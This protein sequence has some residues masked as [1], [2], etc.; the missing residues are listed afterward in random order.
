MRALKTFSLFILSACLHNL[1]LSAATYKE[2]DSTN[3]IR[4]NL[5][6]RH[7]N[8]ICLEGKKIK[9]IMYPE[10]DVT[11]R[12]DEDSG[13][14]FVQ[15]LVS[16][17]SCTTVSI[18]TSDGVVQDLEL[19]F[20][21]K[22]SE[23]L[24]LKSSSSQ[25]NEC[26]EIFEEVSPEDERLDCIQSAIRIVYSGVVPEEYVVVMAKECFFDKEKS[27]LLT[28]ESKLIGVSYTVYLVVVENR[29]CSTRRISET[30]VNFLC[31]EWVWIEKECLQKGE[32]S[33][34]LIG[35]RNEQL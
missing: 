16:M 26:D 1:E 20:S 13:Q 10:T 21:D 8:R 27:L 33:L 29:T 17:P 35:V 3:L 28:S 7:H 34:A 6:S 25:E 2:M 31:G 19:T 32:K 18:I 12:L 14:L 15:P 23:I 30:D 11:I 5:S 22:S 4:C 24:I 9:K